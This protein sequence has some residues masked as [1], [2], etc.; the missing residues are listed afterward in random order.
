MSVPSTIT[1]TT[2]TQT[3]Q[4]RSI[5]RSNVLLCVCSGGNSM[6]RFGSSAMARLLLRK[7]LGGG[8]PPRRRPAD[9]AAV[10]PDHPQDQDRDGDDDA[11][12]DE[13]HVGASGART[14][15]AVGAAGT[16]RHD[17][18]ALLVGRLQDE[19][20]RVVGG[21]GARN[22]RDALGRAVN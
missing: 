7:C 13:D 18:G 12:P 14:L 19:V 1:S 10:L 8:G 16:E 20:G 22:V 2:T 9:Q 17:P 3:M 15:L 21:L 5:A 6:W 4:M 11:D